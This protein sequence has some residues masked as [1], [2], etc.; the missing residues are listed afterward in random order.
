MVSLASGIAIN[1]APFKASRVGNTIIVVSIV[2]EL[3]KKSLDSM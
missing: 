2:A 1:N 3:R